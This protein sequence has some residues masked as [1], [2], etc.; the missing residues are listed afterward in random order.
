M[1]PAE[2]IEDLEEGMR[3][4]ACL[5]QRDSCHEVTERDEA[6]LAV[7]LERLDLNAPPTP[8]RRH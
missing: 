3:I 2:R 6:V 4:I 5:I 1:S 8:S 7:V